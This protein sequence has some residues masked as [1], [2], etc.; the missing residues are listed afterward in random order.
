MAAMLMTDHGDF[1]LLREYA[2][3]GSQAAFGD[4]VRRYID[5]VYTSAA[6]QVCDSHAA[7]DITQTVFIVLSKKAQQI[8]SGSVLSGWLLSVTR[9]AVKDHLK[10]S[11]R[12]RHYEQAAALERTAEMMNVQNS[13]LLPRTEQAPT[14]N[15]PDPQAQ[16]QLATLLDDALAKL[17][18]SARDAVVLRFYE[19]QSF[20]QVGNRLG[21]SE[22]AAR[23]RVFRGLERLRVILSRRGSVL[24]AESLAVALTATT[25]LPAP[26]ALAETVITTATSAAL[27][28]ALLVKGTVSLMRYSTL[29]PLL[30]TVLFLLVLVGAATAAIKWSERSRVPLAHNFPPARAIPTA[31][32][33]VAILAPLDIMPPE[34][35]TPPNYAPRNQ[36]LAAV[37]PGREAPAQPYAGPP[38]TGT[39]KSSDG[40]PLAGAQVTLVPPSSQNRLDLVTVYNAITRVDGRFEFKPQ[41][42]PLGL[43]VR[44]AQG[45]AWVPVESFK[46][47]QSITLTSWARL[48][49]IVKQGATPLKQARVAVYSESAGGSQT[50]ML[51]TDAEGRCVTL[52]QVVGG[53]T[54]LTWIPNTAS[55][56]P[57]REMHIK[58]EPGKTNRVTLGGIGRP[59]IGSIAGDVTPFNSLRGIL[60]PNSPPNPAADAEFIKL[61]QA[62]QAHRIKDW[63]NSPQ[64]KAADEAERRSGPIYFDAGF[65][66]SFK[67]ADVPPGDY[68]IS[69]DLGLAQGKNIRFTETQAVARA[70]FKMPPVPGGFSDEPLDIGKLPFT[71]KKV[72][73]LG[74]PFPK[75]TGTT[76]KG[77][78]ISMDDFLERIVLVQ[79]GG[80]SAFKSR[81]ELDWL[82]AVRARFEHNP[83]FAILTVTTDQ[84]FQSDPAFDGGLPPWQVMR[85]ETGQ[86]PEE[87][88][89]STARMFLVDADG[90]LAAKNVTAAQVYAMLDRALE[91]KAHPRVTYDYVD[92][93]A[94]RKKPPYDNIP[95]PSTTDAAGGARVTVI[96]GVP[97]WDTPKSDS[98]VLTD[99]KMPASE[100]DPG[101]ALFFQAGSLE[102][103]FRIDLKDLTDVAEIRTYSWHKDTRA[104]QVFRVFGSD[105]TDKDFDA[106]PGIGVDPAKHGWTNI[107]RVDTRPGMK[108]VGVQGMARGGRYVSSISDKQKGTLGSYKYLLFEVFVTEADDVFGHT[109]YNEIDVIPHPDPAKKSAASSGAGLR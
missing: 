30:V 97:S 11:R 90:S 105:G 23:Q 68:E 43:F 4:L 80:S 29:K 58:V 9:F 15:A 31:G 83:I 65:D 91:S 86:L 12:R 94:A 78:K 48:E 55:K 3:H 20:K 39:I 95:A 62:E 107:A 44:S 2:D 64:K 50:G 103:R 66:G 32:D 53:E 35:Y 27:P 102:G 40:Q 21:I 93:L 6:R 76:P 33:R 81:G 19:K 42:Q 85:L 75:L 13:P 46:A 51:I 8:K 5:L 104:A 54:R 47:E 89:A 16:Q 71:K 108:P 57:P 88:D 1:R 70:T 34:N 98:S 14:Q 82:H 87:L 79:V 74:A 77:E 17:G 72:L 25:V 24:G 7:E 36:G 10:R 63:E 52:E 26:S 18:A 100:D 22:L 45:Y 37:F 67:V 28:Y 92:R 84:K 106:A 59:V 101:E 96:S 109:F 99:G 49:I 61:P 56:L 38:I 73:D 41:R 60:R 69:I